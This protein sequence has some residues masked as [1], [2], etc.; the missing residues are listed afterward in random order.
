MKVSEIEEVIQKI[1]EQVYKQLPMPPDSLVL[2][3]EKENIPEEIYSQFPNVC[4]EINDD[5][6]SG[7]VVNRL[8]ISQI[9]SIASLQDKD[10]LTRRVFSFLK[11]GKP[12]LVLED[13]MDS[14]EK[15]R[16]KYHLKKTIQE[17]MD[18]CQKFGL[19]FYHVTRSCT[20]FLEE[21]QKQVRSTY[22]SKRTYITEEQLK[23]MVEEGTPLEKGVQLTP[24]AKDYAYDH[25]LFT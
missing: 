1:T 3:Q 11:Q 19:H 21:C 23:K 22:L 16:L 25:Q 15:L 10:E 9:S 4:W 7:M 18:R 5:N 12:V 14:F 6:A 2:V 24:L 17:Y 20:D 8:T 13:P